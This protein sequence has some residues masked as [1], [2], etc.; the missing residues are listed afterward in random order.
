M[1]KPR[2]LKAA[3][4]A[5][6]GFG[7]VGIMLL[8][9]A[10]LL[11]VTGPAVQ[12]WLAGFS[13]GPWG[14]IAAV[15]VFAA[16]SFVGAPQFL[17]IAAAVAAFGPWR[18][19]GYSWAGTMISAGVG[20]WLGRRVAGDLLAAHGGAAVSRFVRMIS[21]NGFVASLLVR[22]VPAAPFVLINMAAGATPM[23]LADFLAGTAIGVVPK[24]A[25]IALGATGAGRAAASDGAQGAALVAAAVVLWLA[26][27][28]A[29]RHWS[30]RWDLTD[31]P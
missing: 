2:A 15:A 18:G 7:G 31:E 21:C 4:L 12:A 28:W 23:P 19:A 10:H 27:G 9:G 5:F 26:L 16:L 25:V 17:L 13:D 6:A 29:A 20:F 24:V 1:F 3:L 14:L 30:R 22:L 8:A 11:G